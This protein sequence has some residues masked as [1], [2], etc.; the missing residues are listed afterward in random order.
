MY[1]FFSSSACLVSLP[2]A[3]AGER[4]EVGKVGLG[5]PGTAEDAVGYVHLPKSS[6]ARFCPR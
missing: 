5:A 6:S 3:E 2:L 1:F 4:M